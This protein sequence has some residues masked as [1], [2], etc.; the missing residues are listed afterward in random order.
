MHISCVYR[1]K[2]AQAH[3]WWVRGIVWA[4]I[5]LPIPPLWTQACFC[6]FSKIY[7]DFFDWGKDWKLRKQFILALY[8]YLV[9][10][11]SLSLSAYLS[12]NFLKPKNS[13]RHTYYHNF[14]CK[15]CTWCL[16]RGIRVYSLLWVTSGSC[17]YFLLWD[18]QGENL[19]FSLWRSQE[20][21][22][23]LLESV[24]SSSCESSFFSETETYLLPFT[25]VQ[26]RKE[27]PRITQSDSHDLL[28]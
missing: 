2:Q 3:T 5:L 12:S 15:F 9:P 4:G 14:T 21:P 19:Q 8:I 7:E 27:K 16:M 24:F 6:V 26:G 10:S 20:P 18:Q 11:Y 28:V 1:S 17:P 23:R 22:C 13:M 25:H